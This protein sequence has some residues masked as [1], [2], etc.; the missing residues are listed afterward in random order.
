M[1]EVS[2]P[3]TPLAAANG[4]RAVFWEVLQ[5]LRYGAHLAPQKNQKKLGDP[6][7]GS[8]KQRTFIGAT[9]RTDEK[10][11]ILGDGWALAKQKP[12][13]LASCAYAR[14]PL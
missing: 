11:G 8:G 12:R 14:Q 13:A 6:N 2:P 1:K 3:F 9:R 7:L 4:H 5:L 10:C